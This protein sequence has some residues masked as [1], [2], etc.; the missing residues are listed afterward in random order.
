M[1]D[2]LITKYLPMDDS[3]FELWN[4]DPL[5]FYFLSKEQESEAL[6]REVSIEFIQQLK[7]RFP[8]FVQ[9]Y[10]KNIKEVV[11]NSIKTESF[12]SPKAKVQEKEAF[13]CFL[14]QAID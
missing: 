10:T 8:D 14:Q 7:M 1:C 5:S 2:C 6:L 9:E 11:Q 12:N 13:F 4:E 3:E